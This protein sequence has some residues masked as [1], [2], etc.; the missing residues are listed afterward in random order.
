MRSMLRNLGRSDRAVSQ[1]NAQGCFLFDL[2][3]KT[4]R[5]FRVSP[6]HF[7]RLCRQPQRAARL[8]AV[9]SQIVAQE[10]EPGDS[11]VIRNAQIGAQKG[12][13]FIFIGAAEPD[14]VFIGIDDGAL[15]KAAG[16]AAMHPAAPL[17]ENFLDAV[18]AHGDEVLRPAGTVIIGRQGAMTGGVVD[19]KGGAESRKKTAT[20]VMFEHIGP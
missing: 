12:D 16:H 7:P 13:H 17:E 14:P 5:R 8:H 18:A 2:R 9:D 11:V 3:Q 6:G 10:F 19:R 4:R 1:R 15:D 20:D